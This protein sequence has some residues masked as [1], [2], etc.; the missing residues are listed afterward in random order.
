MGRGDGVDAGGTNIRGRYVVESWMTS[1]KNFVLMYLTM[2]SCYLRACG[3]KK[4][5]KTTLNHR[6]CVLQLP[7]WRE[8]TSA[9]YFWS[10][11]MVHSP[12]S[13][14]Q[15][16]GRRTEEFSRLL[17]ISYSLI[18]ATCLSARPRKTNIIH[19]LPL[20]PRSPPPNPSSTRHPSRS[21][22]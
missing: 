10:S 14:A 16:P 3:L 4:S 20:A 7:T 18:P 13:A 6:I 22:P 8:K 19:H 1:F 11:I 21:R 12:N 17:P 2:E 9:H 15:S 5:F